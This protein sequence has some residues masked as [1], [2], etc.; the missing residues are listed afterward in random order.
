MSCRRVGDSRAL[1][2]PTFL[3]LPVPA[4]KNFVNFRLFLLQDL[5]SSMSSA[6]F[7]K[8]IYVSYQQEYVFQALYS[9]GMP[10]LRSLQA[11]QVGA[12]AS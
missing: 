4:L 6:S 5:C 3:D 7:R 10:L 2:N 1:F 9:C 12:P 11:L 8:Y